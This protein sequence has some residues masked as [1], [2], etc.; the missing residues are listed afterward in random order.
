[1]AR[2]FAAKLGWLTAPV[3][4]A[5]TGVPA[6]AAD[7]A[8]GADWTPLIALAGGVGIGISLLW[9]AMAGRLRRQKLAMDACRARAE[10]CE[11]LRDEATERAERMTV[12]AGVLRDKLVSLGRERDNFRRLLNAA[13]V[14]V[15]RRDLAG[16]IVWRND[17]HRT[18]VG[19]GSDSDE[20]AS[21]ID[22]AQPQ[23][24][25]ARARD[26]ETPVSE[27]RR[28]VV[29]GQRRVFHVVETPLL[30]EDESAGFAIDITATDELRRELR[31][32][33][34]AYNDVL[35]VMST[36]VAIYDRD[37]RLIFANK[38]W[39]TLWSLE[40]DFVSGRPTMVEVLDRLYQMRK[41]PEQTEYRQF[42]K[43][44]D[45]LFTTLMEPYEELYQRP[46]ERMLRE[47][48]TRHAFGGLLFTFDDAT[49]RIVLERNLNTYIATLRAVLDNLHEAVAVFGPDGKLNLTNV[50]YRELWGLSPEFVATDPHIRDVVDLVIGALGRPAQLLEWRDSLIASATEMRSGDGRLDLPDG[51][52]IEFASTGLP[53]GRTLF[54]YL[55][56]TDSMRIE[57]ALRERNEALVAADMI[58][59]EFLENMSYELRTPLNTILGFTE[60]LHNDY[61][62]TLNERQREYSAGILEASEQ[63]LGMINDMLDLAS[64]QAG[65]LQVDRTDFGVE[66]VIDE[67]IDRFRERADR[68]QIAMRTELPPNLP[69]LH[70]DSRRV[71]QILGNLVSNA[72][73]FTPPGGEV[74]VGAGASG[75][76][77]DIWVEDNGIGIP[78]E[79]QERVFET[80]R[81]SDRHTRRGAGLGLALVRNLMELL[82][83]SVE[84]RSK[85]GVGTTV[86]CHFVNR[87]DPGDDAGDRV[88]DLTDRLS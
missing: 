12:E 31:R 85:V 8:A 49:D 21:A 3:V 34:H 30:G 55:D 47:V 74:T 88:T 5:L 42:R 15:W 23:L 46:D 41:L 72:V 59:S 37:K 52:F 4:A 18:V 32:Q 80:F 83:G 20:I 54:T 45:D 63:F 69:L 43:H 71:R 58:K 22:L 61:F 81:T 7:N 77:I 38:A 66:E 51:R 68:R 48:V 60:I 76:G 39:K 67:V 13:P 78:D 25:V 9:L 11:A 24:L 64:I 28:F 27:E 35:E 70:G 79:E 16:D 33:V 62:G 82:G 26:E 29:E 75:S 56:V 50:G 84:L 57:R 44:R 10:A 36:A 1:M 73:K 19:E 65:H 87:R 2:R 17:T 86:N 53:D 40:D 6:R 14:A